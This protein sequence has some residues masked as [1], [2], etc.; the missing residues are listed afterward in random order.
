VNVPKI[1]RSAWDDFSLI[2][3]VLALAALSGLAAALLPAKGPRAPLSRGF[4]RAAAALASL[5]VLLVL[6]RIIDPPGDGTVLAGVFVGLVLAGALALGAYELMQERGIVERGGKVPGLGERQRKPRRKR[7][8][9]KPDASKP[10][11]RKA[12]A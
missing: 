7:D 10:T 1:D 5:S 6:W 4:T 9:A 11:P 12:G 8:S 3:I 2:D